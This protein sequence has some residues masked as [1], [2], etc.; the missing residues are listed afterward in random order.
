MSLEPP[1]HTGVDD[2]H[3]HPRHVGHR[4]FDL[5][6]ALTAIFISGV[7]LY[8]AVEHGRIEQQLVQENA[9]LVEGN[10]RLVEANSWPFLQLD[11]H[12]SDNRRSTISVVNAGI[13]PAKLETLQVF[14]GGRPEPD[15]YALLRD[16]C[17]LPAD[18]AARTG[19]APNGIQ[20]STVAD[21]VLR[22]GET[23]VFIAVDATPEQHVLGVAFGKAAPAITF[24]AC[25]CSV[26]DNCWISDLR[27]LKPEPVASCPAGAPNFNDGP[28]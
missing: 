2:V 23:D 27:G 28:E 1:V 14:Y 10:A 5:I 18:P 3:A 15:V 13:G 20:V 4:W 7:S 26:F 17:G 22:P 12:Y 6:I 9:K 21:S 11:S 19:L 8:V 24:R 16:C 25:Y